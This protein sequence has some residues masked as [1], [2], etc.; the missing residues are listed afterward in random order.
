MKCTF[1]T[2]NTSSE[3]LNLIKTK[4]ITEIT[5]PFIHY[6]IKIYIHILPLQNPMVLINQGI[7]CSSLCE[8]Q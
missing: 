4:N 6:N 5:N 1:M 3:E 7:L 8:L 2:Q